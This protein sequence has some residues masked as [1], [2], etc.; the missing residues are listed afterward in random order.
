MV[1]QNV[2]VPCDRAGTR[3]APMVIAQYVE[4][5]PMQNSN[6]DHHRKSIRIKGYDYSSPGAYFVTVVTQGRKCLFGEVVDGEMMENILGKIVRNEWFN[7]AILRPSA[8][9]KEDEFVV[10]PN[11]VHGIIWLI[12]DDLV[13]ARRPRAPTEE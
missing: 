3:P 1:A 4:T 9:L 10:M 13:G 11:H 6:E 5:Q 2:E 8:Q 12:D 7:T